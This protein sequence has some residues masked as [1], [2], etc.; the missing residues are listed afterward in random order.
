MLCV[1]VI[2]VIEE[3]GGAEDTDEGMCGCDER[4]EQAEG[5]GRTVGEGQRRLSHVLCVRDS[6]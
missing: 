5:V 1:C 3:C 4:A 2:V 6:L